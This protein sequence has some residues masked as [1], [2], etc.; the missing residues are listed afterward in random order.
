MHVRYGDRLGAPNVRFGSKADMFNAPADVRFTSESGH[1]AALSAEGLEV[2]SQRERSRYARWS[3]C[4]GQLR[5]AFPCCCLQART[6]I[7]AMQPGNEIG[8]IRR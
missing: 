2:T 7:H 4:L 6:I 3:S 8:S 1:F 5:Q